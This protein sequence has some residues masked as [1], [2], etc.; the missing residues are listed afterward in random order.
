VREEAK[1]T[2]A[3]EEEEEEKVGVY[4]ITLEQGIRRE[5]CLK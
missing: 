3:Y 4:L 1:K 2:G 5:Y